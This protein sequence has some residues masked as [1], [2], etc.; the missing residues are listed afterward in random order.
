MHSSA[1]A[2]AAAAAPKHIVITGANTGI[3]FEAGLELAKRSY[4]ITLACRNDEK[5]AAAAKRIT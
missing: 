2:V 4:E 3:G 5:A 1:R